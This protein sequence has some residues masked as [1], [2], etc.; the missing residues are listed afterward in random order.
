MVRNCAIGVAEPIFDGRDRNGPFVRL[1]A[2]MTRTIARISYPSVVLGACLL[3]TAC[4]QGS[5]EESSDGDPEPTGDVTG[6]TIEP[7]GGDNLGGGYNCEATASPLTG[8]AATGLGVTGNQVIALAAGR[9]VRDLQW[10]PGPV[11]GPVTVT[12]GPEQGLSEIVIDLQYAGG[13]IRFMNYEPVVSDGGGVT[14]DIGHAPCTDTIE[15]DMLATITTAGGAL[16]ETRTVAVE[17]WGPD[18][19]EMNVELALESLTGSLVVHAT[20]DGEVTV[21]P[22]TLSSS[23]SKLGISGG[24]G[25]MVEITTDMGWL[26]A[27]GVTFARWPA[28]EQSCEPGRLA[29]GVD[30]RFQQFSVTD[31]LAQLNAAGPAQL[32]WQGGATTAISNFSAAAGSA[33]ACFVGRENPWDVAEDPAA[34]ST[35]GDL[36]TTLDI[37][38]ATADGTLATQRALDIIVRAN[39][40]GQVE[41]VDLGRG[42]GFG[43]AVPVAELLSTWG[44]LPFDFT[45][46]QHASAGLSLEFVPPA[47]WSGSVVVYGAIVHDCSNNLPGQGC[48]GTDFHELGRATIASN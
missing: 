44:P 18:Y 15:V 21:N 30:D 34:Q 38:V 12:V 24:L 32:T 39:D 16:A 3:A 20:G 13:E 28:A 19:A 1:I 6:P 41:G 42:M 36:Y 25:T 23:I 29:A 7:S 10:Q 22:P 47:T 48:E 31:V 27:G 33:L 11:E 2:G 26:G 9:H 45:G 46:Y 37:S 14:N 8:D 5:A 4:D 43:P 17:A 40:A 35:I